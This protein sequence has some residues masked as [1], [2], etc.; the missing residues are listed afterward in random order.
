MML[1]LALVLLAIVLGFAVAR[2]RGWPET[3]AAV[4]AVVVLVSAGAISVHDA[5]MEMTRLLHAVFFLGAVLVLAKL[6]DDE[7][8]FTAAGAAIARA[9]AGGGPT[10]QLLRN[11]FV[12][13]SILTAALGLDATIVLFTPAV[14]ATV[15]W[16]RAPERPHAYATVQ[17]THTASLLLPVSNLTN[18]L[19]FQTAGIS[20]TKFM[21]VMTLP[22]L[23][24]STT[25][26]LVFRWFFA[27]DLRG[28]L[29]QQGAGHPPRLPRFVVVV[30]VLTL[31]GFAVAQTFGVAPA[32][33]AFAG[34]SVLAAHGLR[35]GRS[36]LAGIARS[37]NVSF[38]IFVLALGVVVK[39]VMLNGMTTVM[40]H[41]VPS[42]SGL[43]TLLGTAVLAAVLA[44]MVNN[45]PATLVLLPLVAD[46]GPAAVLAV[47]IGVDIGPNLSYVGSLSNLLWR[48]VV[49]RH[50]IPNSVGEYTRL[51]LCSTPT[52]LVAAVLALWASLRLI[53]V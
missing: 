16:L 37:A 25:L 43:L 41:V 17:L 1:I 31:V 36:S 42:G 21:V 39:A 33:A 51:G 7:G 27:G 3:F 23:A 32:W 29:D 40:S 46:G 6:C 30:V 53:A 24:S 38:L 34:A 26:Y 50:Q 22:W 14:L 15:R 2:P 12:V 52:A 9:S 28:K 18:L 8:L 47:L 44:N 4:P 19:A 20:F 13:T 48:K 35:N 49:G 10:R 45:V 5:T 11:M